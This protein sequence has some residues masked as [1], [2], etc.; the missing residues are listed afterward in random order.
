MSPLV[1]FTTFKEKLIDGSKTQTIRRPRKYPIK[2]GDT[3][4]L[5]WKLRTNQCQK[6]GEGRVTK[7]VTKKLEEMTNDDAKKDGFVD[8]VEFMDLFTLMHPKAY[9]DDDFDIITWQWTTKL[10]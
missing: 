6:L 9:M 8:I 10:V 7:V 4:Y 3:L 2:V 1:G 5:Y